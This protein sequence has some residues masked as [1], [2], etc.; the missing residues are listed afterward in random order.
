MDVP[1]CSSRNSE[2]KDLCQIFCPHNAHRPKFS[3]DSIYLGSQGCLSQHRIYEVLGQLLEKNTLAMLAVIEFCHT[4]IRCGEKIKNNCYERL[5][6]TAVCPSF[7]SV[8]M[9]V[10]QDWWVMC[11]ISYFAKG[12]FGD[13]EKLTESLLNSQNKDN[14]LSSL[15]RCAQMTEAGCWSVPQ[16]HIILLLYVCIYINMFV[17]IFYSMNDIKDTVNIDKHCKFNCFPK[18]CR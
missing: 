13:I 14:N 18:I 11:L 3:R 17:H 12:F 2:I 16:V 10:V 7:R 5:K 15:Q 4:V 9:A 8:V 6:T 1:N